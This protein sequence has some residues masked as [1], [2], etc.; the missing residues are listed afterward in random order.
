MTGPSD[1]PARRA[2][3]FV[4]SFLTLLVFAVAHRHGL[5]SPFIVNDDTRQQLFWMARWLDPALYPSDLL[6]RY[7]A[8]YVPAGIKALYF[9]AAKGLGVGPLVFSKWLTG[10]LLLV[11]ALAF[12]G[13]GATLEGRVLGYVCAAMAWLMPFFMKNISGGLSRGFAAP[14]LALFLLAWMRRS[15]LA[16]ALI[17]LLQAVFIPYIAVL[18][19]GCACLDAVFARI[20]GRPDAPFPVRPWHG[21]AL[22][23]A[24]GLVWSFKHALTVSGFGPLVGHAA[25]A[26]GPE[27]SAAGRLSLYPLPNPFFDLVYWPFESIGLF[28]D[29][30]LVAGIISLVVLLPVVIIGAKRAPWPALLAKCRPVGALLVGSLLLYILARAVALKL[31]VPD[32]YISYTI[33]LVYAL[34]LAVVLRYALAGALARPWPRVLLLLVAAALGAWRLT[35]VGLYDYRADAPLYAAVRELPKNALLAGNP[36]LLDDVLTFGRRDVLASYELAHPWSVGYWEEY[37]PRLAHQV[38]AYYAK[39]AATVLEFA[40]AYNV[41]HMVVRDADFTG[42]AIAKGPLF[43]PLD[44]RIRELAA[45][46]GKFVLLDAAEFPYTSPEPGVRL[47]DLRPLVAAADAARREAE[48]HSSGN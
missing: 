19:A 31:F 37:Y 13:L 41:T 47:V 21:L 28:L 46:P 18:C 10:G 30:G 38:A 26:A 35:D 42:Q 6:T 12:F 48:N 36:E 25:L 43:A 23:A 2:D 11:L 14:L 45:K 29:I 7:A 3:W 32:R 17:L 1:A 5:A 34:G 4:V 44:A 33:N 9:L 24:A 27:F 15:G 20:Q 40:K 39:D 22:I 8:A 16:M